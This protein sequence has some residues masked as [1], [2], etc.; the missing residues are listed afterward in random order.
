[1]QV[2]ALLLAGR[3]RDAL[4]LARAL[5]PPAAA[6]GYRPVEAA[7]L[8]E[9]GDLQSRSG[10]SRT[11][12]RTLQ[13]AALAAQAG[14][15]TRMAGLTYLG[16]GLVVAIEERQAERGLEQLK[17]AGALIESM[18]GDAWLEGRLAGCEGQVLADND[19]NAEAIVRLER[20]LAL[21]EKVRGPEDLDA[22]NALNDLGGSHPAPA[23]H[24]PAPPAAR[25][26]L[27]HRAHA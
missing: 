18:G 12:E 21:F 11:A 20:A 13:A 10:D 19:R 27:P 26:A 5:A 22:A 1:A 8:H 2:H 25:P 23:R 14:R 6:L 24:P 16:L 7:V 9:L 3:I 15:D 4:A 17:I